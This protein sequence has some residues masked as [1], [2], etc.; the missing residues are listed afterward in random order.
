LHRQRIVHRDIKLQN[1]LLDSK[2]MDNINIKIADF[3]FAKHI[4]LGEKLD[5]KC[6]TPNYMAPELIRG[7]EYEFEVDIWA[8]GVIAYF[9]LAGSHP[10]SGRD[11]I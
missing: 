3:G 6:G 10:F 1:I 8:T 9:L 5:L 2:D 11:R 4:P 7:L